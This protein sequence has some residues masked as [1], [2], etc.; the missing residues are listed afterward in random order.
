MSCTHHPECLDPSILVNNTKKAPAGNNLQRSH[1]ILDTGDMFRLSRGTKLAFGTQLLPC[2]VSLTLMIIEILAWMKYDSHGFL[3]D[4]ITHN[5]SDVLSFEYVPGDVTSTT[6][7]RKKRLIV[8]SHEV[9]KPRYL[10]LEL[11]DRSEI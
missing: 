8:R 10:Y 5:F 4:V 9:S 2:I 7:Y 3:W 1:A 6:S 11:T